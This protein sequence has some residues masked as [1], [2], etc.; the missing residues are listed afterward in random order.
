MPRF[1]SSSESLKDLTAIDWEPRPTNLLECAPTRR[2]WSNDGN[3]HLVTIRLAFVMLTKTRAELID[4]AHR[5]LHDPDPDGCAANM[6]ESLLDSL[7]DSREWFQTFA[8]ALS[9]AHA[10]L[11]SAAAADGSTTN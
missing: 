3:A 4:V 8:D 6:A 7:N 10:R 1:A 9:T 5:L 11:L 2:E